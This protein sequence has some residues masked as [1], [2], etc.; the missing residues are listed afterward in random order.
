MKSLREKKKITQP[1]LAKLAGTSQPQILRLENGE[2][3][4][5]KEWAEKIAPHLGITPQELLFSEPITG[6]IEIVGMVGA[7]T[8]GERIYG[9]GQNGIGWIEPVPG[10]TEKTVAVIVR[11][12]SMRPYAFDGSIIFFD[13]RR[14]PVSDDMLGEVVI[15]GLSDDRILLKRLLRANIPDKGFFNLESYNGDVM[16]DQKVE[17]AAFVAAVIPPRQARKLVR[18]FL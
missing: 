2:R 8:E 17:W 18:D 15:V 10:S 13:D 5:T 3:K 14:D 1:Q 12:N 4:M 6:D 16:P 9:H 11:G 7:D